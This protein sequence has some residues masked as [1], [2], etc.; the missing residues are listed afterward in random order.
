MVYMWRPREEAFWDITYG[1]FDIKYR[2]VRSSKDL[3]TE[4]IGIMTS[5]HTP[6]YCNKDI[7]NL[8]GSEN[9]FP[10]SAA[11]WKIQVVVYSVFY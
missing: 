5:M 6:G 3:S 7:H 2:P 4:Q 11:I 10:L 9:G 1:S 8:T